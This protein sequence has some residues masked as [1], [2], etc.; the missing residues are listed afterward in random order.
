MAT[1]PLFWLKVVL[2]REVARLANREERA[3]PVRPPWMR[4]YSEEPCNY[5]NC[6]HIAQKEQRCVRT[7]FPALCAAT[8]LR[9]GN[10]AWSILVQQR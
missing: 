7:M 3:S 2:G 8:M 6:L 9:S 1:A 5:E 4:S 10:V